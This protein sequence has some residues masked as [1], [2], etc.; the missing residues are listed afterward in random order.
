MKIT[1]TEAKENNQSAVYELETNDMFFE[2]KKTSGTWSVYNYREE[3]YM[4]DAKTMHEAIEDLMI[5][6][7][8]EEL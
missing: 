5:F 4:D 2:I 1:K 8:E 7:G 6:S 3:R